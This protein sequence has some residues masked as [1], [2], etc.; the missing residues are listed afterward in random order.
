MAK[1]SYDVF[2]SHAGADRRIARDLADGLKTRNLKVWIDADLPWGKS[3]RGAIEVALRSSRAFVLVFSDATRLS[4]EFSFEIGAA[5]ASGRVVIPVIK[6]HPAPETIPA[7]LLQMRTVHLDAQPF[8]DAVDL[9]A[10]AVSG[11]PDE[12]PR[13]IAAHG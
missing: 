3:I 5:W 7:Q 11:A 10:E 13:P 8:D 2:I 1:L 9:I 12:E 4:P 6:G